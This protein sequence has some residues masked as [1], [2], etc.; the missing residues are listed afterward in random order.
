MREKDFNMECYPYEEKRFSTWS[1][2]IIQPKYDGDRIRV[3]IEKGVAVLYSS[4]KRVIT[5]LPHLNKELTSM[6]SNQEGLEIDCEGYCHEMKH[7]EISG[8]IRTTRFIPAYSSKIKLYALDLPNSNA[9][10]INR[11]TELSRFIG[12]S[13]IIRAVPSYSLTKHSDVKDFLK[14]FYSQGYEGFVIKNALSLYETKRSVNWMKYKPRK[15]DSYK[16]I[17]FEE[18]VD[19]WGEL[20]NTLGALILYCD[21]G[22]FNVGTG[23]DDAERKE[24]WSNKEK[25]LGKMF[26]ISYQELSKDG[27]PREP[28]SKIVDSLL[29][30]NYG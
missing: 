1:A 17:G 6:Y 15:T 21:K 2:G 26:K 7:P 10:L 25:Y 5:S 23:F 28:S 8:I 24:I 18:Q 9:V 4:S 11:I 14:V 13:G 19:K 12:C 29:G 30:E 27:I 3:K 20:K 22:T 16:I